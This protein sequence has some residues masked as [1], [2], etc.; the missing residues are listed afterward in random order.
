MHVQEH[1]RENGSATPALRAP[2][3]AGHDALRRLRNKN[4]AR[5]ARGAPSGP[6][7]IG[8]SIR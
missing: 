7:I 2:A 4:R 5:L 6:P 3:S 1:E 8:F